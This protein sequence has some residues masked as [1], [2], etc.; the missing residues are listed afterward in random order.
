MTGRGHIDI[1]QINK[2]KEYLRMIHP[3]G[4]RQIDIAKFVGC[5]QARAGRLMDLLSGVSGNAN[6]DKSFLV[7]ADDE[8]KPTEYRIFRDTETGIKTL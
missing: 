4:A 1:D 5:E 7:F 6:S 8:I 3:K 2:A